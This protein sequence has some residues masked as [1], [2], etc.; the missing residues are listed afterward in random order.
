MKL[1]LLLLTIM[2]LMH[3]CDSYNAG[4]CGSQPLFNSERGNSRVVGGMDALPG[5]WPWLVSIQEPSEGGHVHMCGGSLL[6]NNW[7]LTAAHCFKNQ[8]NDFNTWRM[9]FGI[10]QLSKMDKETQIRTIAQKIQ[11]ENY[12]PEQQRNDIALLRLDKPVEFND[13]IEPACLPDKSAILKRMTDCYIA[14]WG[15]VKEGGAKAADVLQEARLD[16]IFPNLCNSTNWYNG[17]IGDYNLCAGY[18]EG[19]IDSC[20]GDSGGPLICKA[21]G[22]SVFSVVGV[23]SW[24]SGC[25]KKQNPGV[26]TSTQYYLDWI[27]HHIIGIKDEAGLK[28]ANTKPDPDAHEFKGQEME[29]VKTNSVPDENKHVPT[30]AGQ[31]DKSIKST[32][33]MFP[34]PS[35][36]KTKAADPK[37]EEELIDSF[38]QNF[39]KVIKQAMKLISLKGGTT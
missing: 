31:H 27:I 9:V 35:G 10:N 20:Q 36:D 30:P 2:V 33:R 19:G 1:H 34:V 16:M 39:L 26:Y 28:T 15:V 17:V 37:E 23:G 8:G 11:H 6:N 32:G 3:V 29:P 12:M 14:G 24:G 7:V 22:D 38:S 21:K 13:F 25:A 4:K 18:E 5:S